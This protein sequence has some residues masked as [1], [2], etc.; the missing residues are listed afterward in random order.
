MLQVTQLYAN[1]RI[2][3]IQAQQQFLVERE[4]T[5]QMRAEVVR[6]MAEHYDLRNQGL[7]SDVIRMLGN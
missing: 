3:E 2:A 1:V 7:R 6:Y 5:Q 4:R